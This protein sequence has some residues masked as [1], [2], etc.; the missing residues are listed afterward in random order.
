MKSIYTRYLFSSFKR[1]K[2]SY[3][4]V[5]FKVYKI[6]CTPDLTQIEQRP[7]HGTTVSIYGFHEIPLRKNSDMNTICC[8]IT[9]LAVGNLEV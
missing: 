8:F 2:Q 9:A 3:Y 5:L 7:S 6:G 4:S 1:S